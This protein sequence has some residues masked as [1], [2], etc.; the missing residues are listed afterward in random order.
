MRRQGKV[1][2]ALQHDVIPLLPVNEEVAKPTFVSDGGGGGLVV[3]D[4]LARLAV[5][6]DREWGQR[7]DLLSVLREQIDPG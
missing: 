3:A 5:D 6:G 1:Q 2:D 7:A 4:R